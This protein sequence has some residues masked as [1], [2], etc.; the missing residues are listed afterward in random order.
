MKFAGKWHVQCTD[1]WHEGYLT[2]EAQAYINIEPNRLGAFQFGLVLGQLDG[3][4]C[5]IE[6]QEIFHFRWKGN[7]E[8]APA[9]GSG[10]CKLKDDGILEGKIKFYSG[11]SSRFQA[12]RA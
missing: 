7:D 11:D 1:M 10:W 3:E 8:H 2:R 4:I 6:G 9:F 12:E 5:E